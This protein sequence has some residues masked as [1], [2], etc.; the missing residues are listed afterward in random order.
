MFFYG[1]MKLTWYYYFSY[2]IFIWF[3]I[4]KMGLIKYSPYF[5]Y[6]LTVTFIM[7]KFFRDI[8]YFNFK[9]KKEIKN[10]DLILA[11]FLLALILDII[12]FF[13]L[14]KQL[15]KESIYFTVLL[16]LVY[17]IFMNKSNINVIDHYAV[18][19]YRELSDKYDLKTFLKNFF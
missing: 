9:D 6:V 4:F 16:A 18:V 8:F 17:V 2:W 19:N 3:L 13:F 11:W 12:P 7:L 5:V 10:K 15:D 14:D 1:N